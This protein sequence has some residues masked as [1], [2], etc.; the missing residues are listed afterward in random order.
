M[1]E[2]QLTLEDAAVDGSH[3]NDAA[4]TRRLDSM[5]IEKKFIALR[6]EWKTKRGHH[7][8]TLK[9][10]MHPAYQQII[11]LGPD[12]IPLLLREL[13]TTPDRWYWALRALTGEDPVSP[14][15]RGDSAA[16]VRA[17]LEWGKQKGFRW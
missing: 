7:S 5:Q 17:W 13:A 11:G 10:V 14:E 12:V 4:V 2:D 3:E 16:M 6:D 15:H 1:S 8:E 9:L